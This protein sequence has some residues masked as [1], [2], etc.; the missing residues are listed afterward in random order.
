MKFPM[1]KIQT[2]MRTAAVLEPA[3]GKRATRRRRRQR[4]APATGRREGAG[5]GY[6]QPGPKGG[7]HQEHQDH[8]AIDPSG[9]HL[10]GP[11]VR[12]HMPVKRQQGDSRMSML[13]S[14]RN[15]AF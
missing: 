12:E 9:G 7:G 11:G 1:E 15:S 10:G 6:G 13:C 14:D 2:Q 5:G 4:T 3:A 8:R